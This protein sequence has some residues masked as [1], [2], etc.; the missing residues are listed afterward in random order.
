MLITEQIGNSVIHV[1]LKTSNRQTFVCPG[2]W[3]LGGKHQCAWFGIHT[4]Y[5][6]YATPSSGIPLNVPRVTYYRQ[7]TSLGEWHI[8]LVTTRCKFSRNGTGSCTK[9]LMYGPEGKK[10]VSFVFPGV[11]MFPE[12]KSRKGKLTK[13]RKAKLTSFPRDHILSVLLYI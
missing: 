11:L 12:T 1:L 13:S 6:S 3:W 9:H 7:W 2:V 10:T 5:S 4:S 8:P